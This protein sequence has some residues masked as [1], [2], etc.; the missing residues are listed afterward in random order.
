MH[1][2]A[3]P[4]GVTEITDLRDAGHRPTAARC[5]TVLVSQTCNAA[6][7]AR[8]MV[9]NSRSF[10]GRLARRRLSGEIDFPS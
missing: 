8:L 6:D 4:F 9:T 5:F 3:V 10:S 2:E 7:A 1:P